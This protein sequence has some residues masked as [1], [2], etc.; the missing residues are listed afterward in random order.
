MYNNNVFIKWIKIIEVFILYKVHMVYFYYVRVLLDVV[1]HMTSLFLDDW[2][3]FVRLKI[4]LRS[5]IHD[6]KY[7]IILTCI[8]NRFCLKQKCSTQI[9]FFA[10]IYVKLY[11]HT[12]NWTNILNFSCYLLI[13][14]IY[15]KYFYVP[16]YHRV[17]V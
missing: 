2:N 5:G 17:L 8:L 1:G 16:L 3:W 7:R 4:L 15:I 12:R 10:R 11:I 14:L 6:F 9:Q 13:N